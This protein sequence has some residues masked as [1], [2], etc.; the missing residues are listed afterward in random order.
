MPL[1]T[2]ADL[3]GHTADAFEHSPLDLGARTI[4]C[5]QCGATMAPV[6]SLGRGLT[7]FEE[8]RGRWIE[9]LGPEPVYVTSHGQHRRLLRERKL[10]WATKWTVE[11]NGGWF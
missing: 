2:F 6:L 3:D 8:G 1:Y 11:K 9:N 7:Y 5:G 10:D 4:L